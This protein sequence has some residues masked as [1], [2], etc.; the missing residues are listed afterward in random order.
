MY[1]R[2]A[3]VHHVRVSRRGLVML[4]RDRSAECTRKENVNWT[5]LRTSVR[6]PSLRGSGRYDSLGRAMYEH[7]LVIR[8]LLSQKMYES[9]QA[10]LRNKNTDK[11]Q[12]K[13]THLTQCFHICSI[14]STSQNN[15]CI[16]R[17]CISGLQK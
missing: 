2:N 5:I 4:Y 8:V 14:F 16:D 1:R 12:S 7:L 13:G 9:S 11:F 3:L 6:Y 10:N 15:L 17:D